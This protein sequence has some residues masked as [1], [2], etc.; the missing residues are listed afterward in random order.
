MALPPV[1]DWV[2]RTNPTDL[3]ST[4]S[5]CQRGGASARRP[6]APKLMSAII[7][8]AALLVC[9]TGCRSVP[10]FPVVNLS[11]PGWTVRQGQVVWRRTHHSPEVAG[12]ILV[13]TR[14]D[15]RSFV[16]FTKDPFPLIVAQSAP[17]EWEV[18]LPMQGQ[19]H[20]GHG[21]PPKRLIWLWL[22]R[23]LAGQALPRGWTWHESS[24]GWTLE[25]TKSGQMLKGYFA[26]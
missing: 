8:L 21:K 4:V 16:Q 26:K 11:A 2:D 17:H 23:A 18:K 13:A 25:D 5:A 10:P 15:G 3:S 20:A 6:L 1:R 19:R 22:P 12:D 9:F 7:S 24:K 14:P